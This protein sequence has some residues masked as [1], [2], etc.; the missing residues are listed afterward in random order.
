MFGY[1]FELESPETPGGV[2]SS[3]ISQGTHTMPE[4]FKTIDDYLATVDADKRAVLEKL[5]K[6]IKSIVPK[7]EECFSY[8]LPAFRLNGK[9]VAAF[10]AAAKHCAYYPMSGSVIAALKEA[11]RDYE[12]SKGAI[13]FQAD[14]PLPAALVRKLIK[15]RLAENSDATS[16]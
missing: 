13:R 15:A 4:K 10:A 9:P 11:L 5:R 12:T 3:L 2:A 6:T 8:G 7:A 1:L 14:K 16:A